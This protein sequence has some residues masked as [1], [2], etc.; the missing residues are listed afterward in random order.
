[1]APGG[2][3][4]KNGEPPILTRAQLEENWLRL[5]QVEADYGRRSPV[6]QRA[7]AVLAAARGESRRAEAEIR[8]LLAALEGTQS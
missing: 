1:L 4:W 3:A 6:A 5:K 7:R 8:R 2:A